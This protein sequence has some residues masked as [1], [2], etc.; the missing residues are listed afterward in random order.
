MGIFFVQDVFNGAS[1]SD[2]DLTIPSGSIVSY[3]PSTSGNPPATEMVFGLLETM[4]RAVAS[5][6]PVNVTSTVNSSFGNNVLSRFYTFQV[7]LD[8]NPEVSLENLDVVAEPT[9]TTTT[10]TTTTAP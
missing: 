10:T 6:N 1:V 3:V 8:F 2:G 9:T 5:G 7:N 4:H